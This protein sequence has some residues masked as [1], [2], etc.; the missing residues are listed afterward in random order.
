LGGLRLETHG[1]TVGYCRSLLRSYKWILKTPPKLLLLRNKLATGRP[2]DLADVE[3][4]GGK[5]R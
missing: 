1:F 3:R 2:Q 4:V 5:I